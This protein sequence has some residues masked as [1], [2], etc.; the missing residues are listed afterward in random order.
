M[1]D[2]TARTEPQEANLEVTGY[3]L[4]SAILRWALRR[5]TAVG[6]FP[7]T[8][9]CFPG[10]EKSTPVE[11]AERLSRAEDAIAEL[12]TLQVRYNLGIT[13]KVAGRE[14]PLAQGVKML[15]GLGRLE[16]LWRVQVTKPKDRYGY[17]RSEVRNKDEIRAQSRMTPDEIVKRA[18]AV[19]KYKGD[20][21]QAIAEANA[22]RVSFERVEGA[23]FE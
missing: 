9:T 19:A 11:I 23:L 16:K 20:L 1:Q 6:Q 7:D 14:M 2:R 18:E 4:R 21:A 12:Q 22:T 5:D 15:G 13:I 17:D 8:F 10:E 3:M